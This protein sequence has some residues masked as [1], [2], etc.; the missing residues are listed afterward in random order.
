[1]KEWH[2]W[3]FPGNLYVLIENNVRRKFFETMY[4]KFGSQSN[5]AKFLNK[6]RNTIQGHH[7]GRGWDL[8]KKHVKF[9]PLEILH[10]SKELI[11]PKLKEEIENNIIEI[12]THGG[13]NIKNPILPIKESPAFY[14]ITAHILGDGNDSHTPYY[15]NTCKELREQFKKDLQIFGKVFYF[16]NIPNTTPCVNFPKVVTRILSRILDVQFTHP[17]R[18]PNQVFNSLEECKVA[19]LQALFDDEGT[20]STT[21]SIRIHNINILTG[22]KKLLYQLNIS[23]GR[24]SSYTYYSKKGKRISSSFNVKKKDYQRFQEKVNFMHPEKAEKLKSA[25]ITKL[26]KVRTRSPIQIQEQI[27]NILEMKPSKTLELANELSFTIN[28]IIPHLKNLLKENQII[29]RGYKN[30]TIWDLA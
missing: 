30:Q 7:Y 14:R 4:K 10:K 19:F 2:I 28:G 9:M 12:R 1:M 26:R 23:T 18:I 24:I 8:G 29:K 25:L 3:D 20:I 22:L 27:I 21:L 6:E 11:E 15:A 5:Y 13:R 16:E 17:N